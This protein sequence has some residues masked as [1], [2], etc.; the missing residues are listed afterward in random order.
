[1][2]KNPIELFYDGCRSPA[3]KER[4]TRILRNILC[5]VFENVLDGSF[6]E[7][8]SQLVKKS[9]ADPD[10]AMNLLLSL[11]NK[12][13]ERTKLQKTDSN[14]Y[15]PSSFGNYFKPIKKLFDMN[16]VPVVW[17][18]V[19]AT[20]P[21]QDNQ[22]SGRGYSREEIKLMLKFASSSLNR[23]IILVASS[24]GIREGGFGLKWK[25]LLPVYKVDN[26]I[27]L[28]I[29]ESQEKKAQVICAILQI[30]QGT[31]EYY[32]AFITP[33]AYHALMEYRAS[34][35]RD[36]GREPK[37]TDPMFKIEGKVPIMIKPTAIKQHVQRVLLSSGL[38]KQL[39]KGMRRHE[40]PV[41]NGFRRFFNKINKESVSK[42]SPLAS[43]I[44][45]EYM[46]AHTGLVKLDRNYFQTHVL[47]LVEEYL[48]AVPHLTI[49]NEERLKAENIRKQE[50][51]KQLEDEQDKKDE[52]RFKKLEEGLEDTKERVR[53]Y[54]HQLRHAQM[55]MTDEQKKLWKEEVERAYSNE[56]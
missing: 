23:A 35:T 21:E 13:K 16:G 32:P 39:P 53:K 45:K 34:W 6:E 2:E 4:Y 55:V 50:R 9:K 12:V 19:Y 26:D 43:L 37:P 48:N 22:N 17:K 5:N 24:S 25:D 8:A 44:K 10:W 51:I 42:D 15:N 18:R 30:Y 20:F 7:R 29:T 46:M 40:V 49:N 52:E 3:T 27:L 41:M 28:E 47:E 11:S 14:Y 36:V 31:S 56:T 33:E 54:A 1:M 38:R